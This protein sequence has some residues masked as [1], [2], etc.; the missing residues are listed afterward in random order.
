LSS[1][2]VT[3]DLEAVVQRAVARALDEHSSTRFLRPR[4][5]A[6]F[7]GLSAVYLERL[8]ARGEGPPF[9][10]VGRAIKYDR[11]DLVAF[12]HSDREPRS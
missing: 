3:E 8:R 12:A 11:V 10:R 5:A 6:M 9:V 4:E 1:E 2:V 7:L